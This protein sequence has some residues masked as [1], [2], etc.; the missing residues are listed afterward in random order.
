MDFNISH[1]YHHLS[2]AEQ[3]IT[4]FSIHFD[5]SVGDLFVSC[6]YH[7]STFNTLDASIE[8]RDDGL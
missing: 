4:D 7:K 3:I 8:H 1:H 5:L 6:L 2:A